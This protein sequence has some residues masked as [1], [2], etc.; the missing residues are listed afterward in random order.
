MN[1]HSN[2]KEEWEQ[3]GRKQGVYSLPTRFAK[4]ESRSLA[5]SLPPVCGGIMGA[6]LWAGKVGFNRSPRDSNPVR[7]T[8]ERTVRNID[9][10]QQ[11]QNKHVSLCIVT[12]SMLKSKHTD[13]KQQKVATCLQCSRTYT[14]LL[15]HTASQMNRDVITTFSECES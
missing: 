7:K 11:V 9:D 12:E 5:S 4:E 15:L 14:H 1:S 6:W 13:G 2:M 10:C 8:R 3:R